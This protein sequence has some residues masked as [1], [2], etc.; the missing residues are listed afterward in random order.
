MD[1]ET[2]NALTQAEWLAERAALQQRVTELEAQ[3]QQARASIEPNHANSCPT[4][5]KP[6]SQALFRSGLSGLGEQ[7]RFTEALLAA[8]PTPVFFKDAQGRYLGCNDAFTEQMGV[9]AAEIRGKTVYDLWPSEHAAV[10]HQKDLELLQNPERQSYEAMV[11]DKTGQDRDVIF[12]KNVFYDEEGHVAGLVGAYVDITAQKQIEEE[13]RASEERLRLSENRLDLAMA[14]KNEGIWDWNLVTNETFF[15]DRYYTMAGYTPNEFPQNFTAWAERVHPED[16]E[17]ASNAIKAYLDGQSEVFDI[18]FRFRHKDGSWIWIQ[19]KGKIVE[20]DANGSPLRVIGTHTDITERK[21]AEEALHASEQRYR[22]LIE[23]SNDAIYL[24]Y[25]GRFELINRRFTELFGVTPEEAH[26]PDFD[27]MSLV[28]PASRPLIEQRTRQ[29]QAGQPTPSRYEFTALTRA[30]QEIEVEVS[31]SYIAYR[32]G[33]AVQGILHDVSER[34]RTAEALARSEQRFRELIELAVDGILLGSPEGIITGA[35]SRMLAL[36]DMEAEALLGKHVREI[37]TPRSLQENPLRFERLARGETVITE[38]VIQRADGTHVYVE[39]HSKQMPDGSYQ[40]IVHDITER[41]QTEQELAASQRMLKDVINT[42][43]VRVFWKDLEGRFLGCNRLFAQDAGRPSPESLLG[44]NDFNMGWAD[45][46]ELYRADDRTVIELDQ[47]KINYEEP[48]TTPDGQQRWLR[49]SKIPLRDGE[50]HVYGIL[51]VY[52]DITERKHVEAALQLERVQLLSIFDSIDELIYVSDSHT[53]EIVFVNQKLRD[54]LGAE[55]VGGICY[56]AFQGLDAPCSFCTNAV[57]LQNKPT[58]YRWEYHNPTMQ[59]DFAIV[60]RIITWPDGRDVRLELATDITEHKALETQLRRHEQLAAIGQLAAGIAH[61]FRNLLTTII[62]YAQ[63]GQRKPDLPPTVAHYLDTIVDEAHKATGLVQQILDF[64]RRAEIE[65]RPLDLVPFVGN[66]VSVLQRTLPENIHITLDVG[67]GAC[68]IEGDA[69]RLQQALMN[70]ALNARDAMPEGGTL[71]IGVTRIEATPGRALPLSEM[72]KTPAP[73]AWIYLSVADTGTG[74]SAEAYTHRFEPFFT[75]KEPEQGTGLGLAQVYGI[76]QL[77]DG[78]ID[79]TTEQ[80]KGTT[81]HIYLPAAT[82][83]PE[84]TKLTTAPIPPGHGETLLLVEDNA[85]LREASQNL[86]TDLGYRVL[87]AA[88]GRE[89]LALYQKENNIALLITDLVMPEMGGKALVQALH[90]HDP[91]LRALVMTGYT[92][93]ESETD[94][95]AAGF[96]EVIRKPLD[97]EHLAQ[98]IR[99]ALETQ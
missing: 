69:G 41:K 93:E 17:R 81:F 13:L 2:A 4:S 8:I 40:S 59:K 25:D 5:K 39:M 67:A 30:G 47:P 96:L 54:V 97:A 3:V 86:R 44:D 26:A 19:G 71:R 34:K 10:Y 46:A 45:Q 28:A 55:V 73:P 6:A 83:A 32:E 63:L 16:I 23:H 42:I 29:L 79:V 99:R 90:S 33:L 95:Q 27:F 51:G 31:V 77:H 48:Q 12:A 21:R 53:Y 65:R 78:H 84:E 80:R 76:V 98:A 18:E 57:I 14:V 35:N 82:I 94:L 56:Q 22:S 15:D 89:A 7:L 43:P 64:A 1:T 38:R 75:T 72:A 36:L 37:F 85:Q 50:G 20:R 61:D 9:T 70:L 11:R 92:A 87:T 58:P 74:M 52:E 49:T 62:L 60:D 68:V 88:N 91:H 66:V 24:L